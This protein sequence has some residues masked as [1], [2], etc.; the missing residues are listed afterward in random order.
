MTAFKG[1][2]YNRKFDGHVYRNI[3]GVNGKK[4][5]QDY[6]ASWRRETGQSVR[7]IHHRP[8]YY[9]IYAKGATP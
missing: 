6:A 1:R 9:L 3:A 4:K 2:Y 8:G 7:V 5:A